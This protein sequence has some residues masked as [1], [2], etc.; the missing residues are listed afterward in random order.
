MTLRSNI[1]VLALGAAVI[2]LVGV[3]SVN[4]SAQ[5]PTYSAVAW[6]FVG[7]AGQCAPAPAGNKI[8]FSGWLNGMGL[9]DDGTANPGGGTP[10]QG[11]VLNKNGP[12][13]NCSAAGASIVGWTAGGTLSA[14]GFDYRLGGHC[15]AGAPRFNVVDNLNTTY[16]F[17][18]NG[19]TPSAAPQDPANW[20]RITFDQ[21]N[22]PPGFVFGVTMVN[23]IDIVFDEGTDIPSPDGNAP[24][25][26][27]LAT[28][29]NI[30]INHTLITKKAGNPV[31]P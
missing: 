13:S 8:V 5:T 3:L 4:A 26:V 16:F 25:G 2:A 20:T 30:R 22:A 19:G 15:G 27:G 9:P 29:D 24:A 12:E 18:C 10:H 17:G 28:I 14:L 11:L 23:S 7:T 6:I 1:R 21:T 31:L